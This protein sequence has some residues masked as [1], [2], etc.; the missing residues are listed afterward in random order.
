MKYIYN[1]QLFVREDKVTTLPSPLTSFIDTPILPYSNELEA[2]IGIIDYATGTEYIQ[3]IQ[4]DYVILRSLS[5]FKEHVDFIPYSYENH[6]FVKVSLDYLLEDT[7]YNPT[8]YTWQNVKFEYVLLDN[9]EFF[10]NT[11]VPLIN[12]TVKRYKNCIDQILLFSILLCKRVKLDN[13]KDLKH[14]YPYLS[15]SYL[16]NISVKQDFHFESRVGRDDYAYEHTHLIF[17]P[18]KSEEYYFLRLMATE[19]A[20]NNFHPIFKVNKANDVI[21][22][23]Y[24][25]MFDN[26][27]YREPDREYSEEECNKYKEK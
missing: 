16:K 21:D 5:V 7:T 4:L 9:L 23:S 20:E 27:A 14:S 1:G 22:I 24:C 8:T 17:T 13:K 12:W 10:L 25:S 3:P 6:N 15:D 18:Q 26:N 11:I 2:K 19:L